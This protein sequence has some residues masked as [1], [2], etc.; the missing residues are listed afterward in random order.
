MVVLSIRDHG[1]MGI[2]VQKYHSK[3]SLKFPLYQFGSITRPKNVFRLI[4]VSWTY[5]CLPLCFSSFC[6]QC[7]VSVCNAP[8]FF[9]ETWIH[10]RKVL[11]HC[12]SFELLYNEW[13]IAIIEAQW[14]PHFS[15]RNWL[16]G[17][18]CCTFPLAFA[19]IFC[20]VTGFMQESFLLVW[21]A[22]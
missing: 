11:I 14:L 6:W 22:V 20:I 7:K 4:H 13:R 18:V 1:G 10:C 21:N 16:L 5:L 12:L 15:V 17:G 9:E 19:R 8:I 2:S 3:T